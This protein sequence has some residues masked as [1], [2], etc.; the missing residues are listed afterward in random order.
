MDFDAALRAHLETIERRDLDGYVATIHVDVTVVLPNGAVLAGRDAVT[1][2]HRSWFAS[3]TWR[4]R[5]IVERSYTVGATGVALLAT[6]YD[7]VDDTGTPYHSE[8]R[9]G[10]VF[11][12][13]DDGSWLLVYD[14][15]T[16]R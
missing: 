3:D 4:M 7:D 8:N 10:L 13:Q 14:Q 9:L 15:N 16:G 1:E 2:F 11:A 5:T 6:S 12:R